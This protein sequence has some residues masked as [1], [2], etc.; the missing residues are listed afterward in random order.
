M[1]HVMHVLFVPFSVFE[2]LIVSFLYD[3]MT[4]QALKVFEENA[5]KLIWNF[6]LNSTNEDQPLRWYQNFAF[7]LY[8]TILTTG[9]RQGMGILHSD[10]MDSLFHSGDAWDSLP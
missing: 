7:F 10:V 1:V 6:P 2:N 5:T 9:I 4:V 8:N 3:N